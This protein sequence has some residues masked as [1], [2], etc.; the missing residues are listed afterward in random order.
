[1]GA[2]AHTSQQVPPQ[3]GCSAGGGDCDAGLMLLWW[4]HLGD[5]AIP[6]TLLQLQLI[7]H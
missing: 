4:S 1:M 2:P 6:L 5:G 3:H 7:Y